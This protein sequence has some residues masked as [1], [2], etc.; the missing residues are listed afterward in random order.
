MNIQYLSKSVSQY[1][2]APV[3][4]TRPIRKQVRQA[5][6]VKSGLGDLANLKETT[7]FLDAYHEN[8]EICT[9][10]PQL[11]PRHV[12]KCGDESLEDSDL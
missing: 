6:P 11:L 2:P 1:S 5:I 3:T 8:S 7:I 9:G 12:K 10:F 4:K